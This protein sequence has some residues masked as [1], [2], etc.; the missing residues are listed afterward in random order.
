MFSAHVIQRWAVTAELFCTVDSFNSLFFV[1]K[2]SLHYHQEEKSVISSISKSSV[3]FCKS[4]ASLIVH[5]LAKDFSLFL[6]RKKNTINLKKKLLGANTSIE[7]YEKSV[8]SRRGS[9][10]G[11]GLSA[12]TS[13]RKAFSMLLL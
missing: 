10:V 11:G 1:Q 3:H 12:S 4:L 9:V 2:C 5:N 13:Q 8:T 6:E 7:S